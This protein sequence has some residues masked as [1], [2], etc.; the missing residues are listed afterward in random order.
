MSCEG[1]QTDRKTDKEKDRSS[2][3]Y[4]DN[5]NGTW[6]HDYCTDWISVKL[7]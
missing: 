5:E 2:P 4:Y 1:I 3:L 7:T 6:T